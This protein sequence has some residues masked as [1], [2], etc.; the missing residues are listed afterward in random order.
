MPEL[1]IIIMIVTTL[2][3]AAI[4]PNRWL[5]K[6]AAILAVLVE[7]LVLVQLLPIGF[8]VA[9][10]FIVLGVNLADHMIVSLRQHQ[11]RREAK[12]VARHDNNRSKISPRFRKHRC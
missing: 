2:A 4:N 12:R 9:A 11:S 8:A 6:L 3:I 5:V 1:P 7:I 10:I